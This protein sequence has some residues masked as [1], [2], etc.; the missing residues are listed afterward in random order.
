[1]NIT[2]AKAMA[3]EMLSDNKAYEK[4]KPTILD[5]DTLETD[6]GWVFFYQSHDF[7]EHKDERKM[8]VG[9]APIFVD[10]DHN[11]TFPSGTRLP[12]KQYIDIYMENRANVKLFHAIAGS[13]R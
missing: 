1:M 4:Y 3:A 8:L 6:F 12:T 11:L 13:V 5:N 2:E 7:I 10:K 9:N